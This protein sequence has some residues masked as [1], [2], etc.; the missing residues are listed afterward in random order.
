MTIEFDSDTRPRRDD[1]SLLEYYL[2]FRGQELEAGTKKDFRTAWTQLQR[3]LEQ[4]DYRLPEMTNTETSEWC[5]FL[6]TQD[7]QE[8]TAEE[9]VNKIRQMIDELKQTP[10]VGSGNPFQEALDTDPF[11]YDD[12]TNKLEVPLDVLRRAIFNIDH[13]VT[14][15]VFVVLLKTGLRCAELSNLDERDVNIDRPIATELDAPRPEIRDK[16]NTIY[17]DSSISEGDTANGEV[18]KGGN[19]P[20]SYRE[21]PLDEETVDL[22]EWYFGQAPA[23]KSPANPIV[24]VFSMGRGNRE[25]GDR[26]G[27]DGI[28]KRVVGIAKEHNWD[29]T[30]GVTPHWCRHWFTTQLRAHVDDNEVP[31]GSTKEYVQGLRGDSDESVIDTYTHE[32]DIDD[33]SKSYPEIYRNNIPTLLADPH[34]DG[35]ITCPSC[36]REPPAVTFSTVEPVKGDGKLC[37]PCARDEFVSME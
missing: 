35:E 1:E 32:W 30:G 36:G 27:T 34:E 37:N 21:I 8:E 26:L 15:F 4:E 29:V 7:I 6:R 24:R 11:S 20:K 28:Y 19:K 5:D 16:P 25:V 13:P 3:F 2:N 9:Y 17:I 10:E 12:S 23:S 14:L 22:F 33:R 18:R 31:V